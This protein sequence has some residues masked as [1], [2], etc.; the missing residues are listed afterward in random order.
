MKIIIDDINYR[1]KI[2]KDL[3]IKLICQFCN[4]AVTKENFG[5]IFDHKLVCNDLTCLMSLKDLTIS[6]E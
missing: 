6:Y 4:K 5:G 1:L 3:N 2:A